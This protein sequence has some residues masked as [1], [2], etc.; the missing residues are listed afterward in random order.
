MAETFFPSDLFPV[1][2]TAGAVT[3]NG[4]ITCDNISMKNALMVYILI[5]LNQAAGHAT[6]FTPLVGTVV[7]T[8]G[9]ALPLAA[10]IWYGN[11]TTS[12]SQLTSVTAA[13][14]YTMGGGVT[15]DVRIIFKIDPASCGAYDCLGMTVSNSGQATNFIS[16]Q[17]L[18]VPRYASKMSAMTATEYLID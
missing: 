4:G 8:C 9:T 16:A 1:S 18:I 7:A 14:S 10:P 13:V 3:T 12:S 6:V 17:Y 5:H 11:V 2:A 15:G